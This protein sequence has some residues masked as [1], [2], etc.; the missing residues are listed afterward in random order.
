MSLVDFRGTNR[1]H[2]S[3]CGHVVWHCSHQQLLYIVSYGLGKRP[4]FR[5]LRWEASFVLVVFLPFV[6]TILKLIFFWFAWDTVLLCNWSLIVLYQIW[7][8]TA[9]SLVRTINLLCVTRPLYMGLGWGSVHMCI[10]LVMILVVRVA[11]RSKAP[12]LRSGPH[13]WAWVRIPF[14]TNFFFC[15]M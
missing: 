3:A 12:D 15:F 9:D 2:L 5:Y 6:T 8:L 14:L 13:M 4:R 7:L 10:N 1:S 11:E